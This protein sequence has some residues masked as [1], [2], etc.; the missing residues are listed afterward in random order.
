MIKSNALNQLCPNL[1]NQT[2]PVS[3]PYAHSLIEIDK[4]TIPNVLDNFGQHYRE[5]FGII[6]KKG[7]VS[8]I[9]KSTS[10]GAWD[11]VCE[12]KWTFPK[13][14]FDRN[15]DNDPLD[16][17]IRAF[18]T[19]T[20]LRVNKS[21]LCYGYSVKEKTI[22]NTFYFVDMNRFTAHD[23]STMKSEN[24]KTEYRWLTALEEQDKGNWTSTSG[25]NLCYSVQR[26]LGRRYDMK[27]K[28]V[29]KQYV[30]TIP[31]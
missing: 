13:T 3:C 11:D 20:G 22:H 21:W 4:N 6:L 10:D 31:V 17:A 24:I 14:T 28:E 7:P 15:L 25:R 27:T 5:R 2:C 8:L 23:L 9:I 18:T 29:E 16:T 1:Y 19:K 12:P 26:F 30:I